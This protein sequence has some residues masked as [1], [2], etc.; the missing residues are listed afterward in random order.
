MKVL[1]ISG[2]DSKYG[3]PKSMMELMIGLKERYDIEPVL[4][5]KKHCI[6][7]EQCDK[8]G[9]ENYFYWYRDIMAGSAYSSGVLNILKHIV[10]YLLFLLG[11][12]TCHFVLKCGLPIEEIDIIHTNLNRLDIG[13]YLAKK[14]NKKHICH[15]RELNVG[16]SKIVMYKPNCYAYLNKG[17]DRFIAISKITRES[18]VRYGLP[19]DKVS[20]IYNG[21]NPGLFLEKQYKKDAVLKLVIVGRIEENKG[22]LQL[23]KAI[24]LLSPEVRKLVKVTIIGE[25]YGEYK[26][27]IMEIL[28]RSD[29]KEQVEFP[30]YVSNVPKELS[31]YDIG[32]VASKGEAFGRITAE[33]MHA[34]LLVLASDTGANPELIDDHVNGMIYHYGDSE[35]LAHRI[36]EIY[37]NRELVELYGKAA[38]EKAVSRF[39]KDRYVDEVYDLYQGLYRGS[40]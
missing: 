2:G 23:V 16:H 34:G 28:E 32:V 29:I 5:T 38:K 37:Q 33:Y 35:D 4:L 19:E 40:K 25:G 11:G 17:I 9:I 15:L 22:Q 7:N 18:W 21:I 12:F 27:K 39:S 26:K 30:G 13:I 1:F 24:T 36:E 6:L 14:Y 10:K 20:V 8:L 3:A 31:F